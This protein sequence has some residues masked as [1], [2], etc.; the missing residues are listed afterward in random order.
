MR[1]RNADGSGYD[2]DT[3]VTE[4]SHEPKT[5]ARQQMSGGELAATNRDYAGV[6]EILVECC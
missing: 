2:N 3:T 5:A 6:G 1:R 4:T